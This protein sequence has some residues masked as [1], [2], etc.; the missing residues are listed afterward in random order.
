M[1]DKIKKFIKENPLDVEAIL[2][3]PS[4]KIE[5]LNIKS[6]ELAHEASVTILR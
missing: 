4:S 1:K 5:E 2:K 6:N 3:M